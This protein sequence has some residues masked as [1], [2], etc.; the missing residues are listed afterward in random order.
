MP[1]G[2]LVE[3]PKA[4]CELQGYVY[5]AWQRH[6]RD[7]RRARRAGAGRGP[8]GQGDRAVRPLQRGLLG[9]GG[10]ASTP[11]PSTAHKRQV[12][13]RRLQ[14]RPLPVVRHRAAA[15]APRRVVQRLMA[16]D[17]WS[18]WGIRTLSSEHPAFN[19]IAYQTGSVWP[20]DNGLIALG[21]APLRLHRRGRP[22]SPATSAG[23]AS[24]FALHQMPEL[25]AGIGATPTSFPVQYLGANVPQAW[26][27]GSSFAF[28][29]A[30]LRLEPD[31]PQQPPRHRSRAARLAARH[32]PHGTAAR[33]PGAGS[34]DHPGRR[35]HEGG[36]ASRRPGHRAAARPD[37]GAENAP[38]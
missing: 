18:G 15:S 24:F 4:L 31:A 19:P 22:G 20:H 25:Y 2:S 38:S 36:G 37:G 17:M 21:F 5:D 30:L 13:T 3:G 14:S 23:A 8:A 16:P 33:R 35:R 11:S 6:G 29:Q 1:D 32:H 12:L 26:A 34:A 10:R 7:L 28:L 27:A 9:R